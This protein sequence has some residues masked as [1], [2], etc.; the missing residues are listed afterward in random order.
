M[1]DRRDKARTRAE[2]SSHQEEFRQKHSKVNTSVKN[3]VA[4]LA[5]DAET[6]T[7]LLILKELQILSQ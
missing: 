7:Y 2:T 6:I 1:N 3:Y 5:T 4:E